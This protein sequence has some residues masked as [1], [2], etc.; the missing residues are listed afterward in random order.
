MDADEARLRRRTFLTVVGAAAA[1]GCGGNGMLYTQDTEP[2]DAGAVGDLMA[3]VWKMFRTHE[4]IVARDARGFFA[5]SAICTH[6]GC[7]VAFGPTGCT[8][9][10]PATSVT[11]DSCCSCHGSSF[12]GDGSVAG[13]PAQAPL[14]H[15]LVT[16]VAGRIE[17]DPGVIIP[18]ET[19]A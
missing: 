1:P 6:Q 16:I 18:P 7:L 8:G 3:P 11:G 14:P 12:R 15:F 2:F 17:V 13:G 10:G 9:Q 19:R 4:T 5:F